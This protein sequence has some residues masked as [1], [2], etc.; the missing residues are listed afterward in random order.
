M[1]P[2]WI[3]GVSARLPWLDRPLLLVC[4]APLVYLCVIVLVSVGQRCP[5]VCV[6]SCFVPLVLLSTLRGGEGHWQS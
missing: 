1:S 5:G 6:L 3:V 2:G 4:V